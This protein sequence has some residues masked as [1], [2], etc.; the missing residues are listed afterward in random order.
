MILPSGG[1]AGG[2]GAAVYKLYGKF[3]F[4]GFTLNQIITSLQPLGLQTWG[5]F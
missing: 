1:G 5:W 4:W 2:G 3:R